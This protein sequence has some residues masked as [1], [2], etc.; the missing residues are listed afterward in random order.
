MSTDRGRTIGLLLRR[1]A[2][3]GMGLGV[4]VLTGSTRSPSIC[5]MPAI[6]QAEAETPVLEGT[7]VSGNTVTVKAGYTLQKLSPSSAR[8]MG[9]SG[10]E[11]GTYSCSCSGSGTCTVVQNP[12]SLTCSSGSCSGCTLIVTSAPKGGNK[13]TMMPPG[14]TPKP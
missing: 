6:G 12:K 2:L 1:L 7:T 10:G 5:P 13:P 3:V 4:L 11:L 8:V 14:G 9:A